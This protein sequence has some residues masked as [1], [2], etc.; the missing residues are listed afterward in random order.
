[1]F[2]N[3]SYVREDLVEEKESGVGTECGVV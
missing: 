3:E 1:M 2:T